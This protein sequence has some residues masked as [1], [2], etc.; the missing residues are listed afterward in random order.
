[1]IDLRLT[2]EDI[3]ALANLMDMAVKSAGLAA[4]KDAAAILLKLEI[5]AKEQNCDES[6][7]P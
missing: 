7:T 1:M 3:A 6:K 4:V 2:Q 5:A